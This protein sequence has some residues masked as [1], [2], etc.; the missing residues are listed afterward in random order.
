MNT[1]QYVFSRIAAVDYLKLMRDMNA[2][3][4]NFPLIK[5]MIRDIRLQ[6]YYVYWNTVSCGH[7]ACS[8][9]Y[10][11]PVCTEDISDID[12]CVVMEL[13]DKDGTYDDGVFTCGSCGYSITFEDHYA[14]IVDPTGQ[15]RGIMISDCAE[16]ILDYWMK[17]DQ[18]QTFQEAFPWLEG[19][20]EYVHRSGVLYDWFLEGGFH[21]INKVK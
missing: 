18:S 13:E 6:V 3:I 4:Y 7:T 2:G 16:N 11:C 9:M 1:K 15:G 12:E 5:K 20:I 10:P 14:S 19:I 17:A 8:P 21:T